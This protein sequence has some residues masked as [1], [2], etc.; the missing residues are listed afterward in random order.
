MIRFVSHCLRVSTILLIATFFCLTAVARG[1]YR[2]AD[3][4]NVQVMDSRAYVSD[5]EGKL[6]ASQRSSL[7]A[8]LQTMRDSLLVETAVVILPSIEG[9]LTVREFA[10]ELFA[11]FG[12]G[13]KKSDRGLLILLLT[14]KGSR[15]IT[16]ETGYGLEGILPDATCKIIQSRIMLPDLKEGRWYEALS[17]GLVEVSKVLSRDPSS[18]VAVNAQDGGAA[19]L[20]GI[21]VFLLCVWILL[22]LL[23]AYSV[24]KENLFKYK[25]TNL[26][27][28]LPVKRSYVPFFFKPFTFLAVKFVSS[29]KAKQFKHY[30]CPSCSNRGYLVRNPEHVVEFD[31]RS[32]VGT[33][34]IL[35]HC[36]HCGYNYPVRYKFRKDIH[37]NDSEG[38]M[39][40]WVLGTIADIFLRGSMGR[41][42]GFSSRGGWGGGSSGGGGASTKF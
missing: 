25:K 6:S 39:P 26:L 24:I 2:V 5:P 32:Q 17:K 7:D 29:I 9:G 22:G 10:N 19:S 12:L 34:E 42:S 20:V 21:F 27:Y 35:F 40:L 31:V 36:S 11:R 1:G 16:F 3:V 37:D 8:Y 23:A 38:G 18:E 4:P 15:E 41:G 30:P 14:D 13:D 28:F 33:K